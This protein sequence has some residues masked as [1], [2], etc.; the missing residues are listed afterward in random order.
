MSDVG[1]RVALDGMDE[2]KQGLG[3]LEE[4]LAKL[5]ARSP[6]NARKL[7]EVTAAVTEIGETHDKIAGEVEDANTRIGSSS[8]QVIDWE[9]KKRVKAL[10]VAAAYEKM[11]AS[12]GGAAASEAPSA[13]QGRQLVQTGG[14][15]DPNLGAKESID[16]ANQQ[17]ASMNRMDAALRAV[18]NSTKVTDTS[19]AELSK[20]VQGLVDKYNPLEVKLRQLIAQQEAFRKVSQFPKGVSGDAILNVEKGLQAEIDK[21]KA[22]MAASGKEVEKLSGTQNGLSLSSAYLTSRMITL[23]RAIVSGNFQ[24]AAASA[25]MLGARVA[26]VGV[27][28]IAAGVAIGAVGGTLVAMA[29]ASDNLEKALKKVET[30]FAA[31]GRSGVLARNELKVFIDQL[32]VMP[33]VSD[34]AARQVV[35]SLASN[36]TI[37]GSMIQ[38]LTGIT[39]DFAEAM[40]MKVP[41]AAEVLAKGFAKPTQAAKQWDERLNF[42]TADQL[43]NIKTLEDQNRLLEA[44]AALYGPLEA[45]LKG[46]ADKGLTPMGRALNEAGN[47]WTGFWKDMYQ[48]D[49]GKFVEGRITNIIGL[50]G[51]ALNKLRGL[52]AAGGTG[53]FPGTGTKQIG[54]AAALGTEPAATKDEIADQIK[55][56]RELGDTF[57]GVRGQLDDLTN[58][59]RT[60]TDALKLSEPG[61]ENYIRLSKSLSETNR[62]MRALTSSMAMQKEKAKE[63]YDAIKFGLGVAEDALK[64][65]LGR[66][67]I[68]YE[69]YYESIGALRR[70]D[71]DAQEIKIKSDIA[72]ARAEIGSV[73]PLSAAYKNQAAQITAL[74]ASLD[75]LI[76]KRAEVT[77][78]TAESIADADYKRNKQLNDEALKSETELINLR[79]KNEDT[80]AKISSSF[81]TI[82]G[83]KAKQL[84]T[85]ISLIGATRVQRDIVLAQQELYSAKIRAQTALIDDGTDAY[86]AAFKAIEDTYKEHEAKLPGL[87]VMLDEQKTKYEDLKEAVMDIGAAFSSAFDDAILGGKSFRD[88]L[89]GLEKDLWRIG[90]RVLVTKPLERALE[91]WLGGMMGGGAGGGGGGLLDLFGLGGG[92]AGVLPGFT[93]ADAASSGGAGLADLIA[94]GGTG[95]ATGGDFMVGG[96]GGIDSQFVGFKASPG[97]RVTVE[98]PRQQSRASGRSRSIVVNGPLI[99]VS[100]PDAG[101]FN[102]Y[103]GQLGADL[104]ATLSTMNSRFR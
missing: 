21:T 23:G 74:V 100:T 47:A 9:E 37:S 16:L 75:R 5:A 76:I 14:L 82:Q 36:Y 56:A 25:A 95:F 4:G 79:E 3:T 42:L 93:A 60:F 44:H 48:S 2:V 28:G 27:A 80:N 92:S 65:Q 52:D 81:L 24:T 19:T 88:I 58:K 70:A 78:Q 22:A 89:S 83:E 59:Q 20:E 66:N 97:E 49:V 103:S 77:R 15:F 51:V 30:A 57:Q 63:A 40:G 98:T 32:A 7:A 94:A 87:I 101:S 33:G 86:R 31:T 64:G 102:R 104:F 17:T 10:E 62:Q 45:R 72:A 12:Q 53:G 96:S 84:G 68:A 11:I 55:R 85:E 26:G 13:G 61:S 8:K 50:A 46:L 71:L 35:A 34:E 90:Q 38:Q 1:I 43:R 41:Q 73:D 67:E 39:V 69:Q 54:G 29:N 99:S 18:N 6:E 91:G